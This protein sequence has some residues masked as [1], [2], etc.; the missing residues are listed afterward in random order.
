MKKMLLGIF[1]MIN[2]LF[3]LVLFIEINTHGFNTFNNSGVIVLI[4]IVI[5]MIGGIISFLNG[6]KEV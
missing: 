4:F 5:L 1:Y 2:A 3:F 6:Y